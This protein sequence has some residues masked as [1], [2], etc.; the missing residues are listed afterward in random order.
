VLTEW[1]PTVMNLLRKVFTKLGIES[2][3]QL[4]LVLPA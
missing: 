4:D 1:L 2:R 3:M